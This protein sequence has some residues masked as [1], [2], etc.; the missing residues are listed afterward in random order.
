M[1]ASKAEQVLE[2][3]RTLLGADS[4]RGCLSHGP[5]SLLLRGDE[6]EAGPDRVERARCGGV[7]GAGNGIALGGLGGRTHRCQP[8]R[9][10]ERRLVEWRA[11]HLVAP[12][13]R[14]RGRRC[15]EARHLEAPHRRARGLRDARCDPGVSSQ[16]R[17]N[18]PIDPVECTV[19][20][21]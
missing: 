10:F 7:D 11:Q 5:S 14:P 4:H 21:R 1:P 18:L 12:A 16:R 3:L 9:A 20:D 19:S 13:E 15:G 8:E 2:A 17:R 6:F